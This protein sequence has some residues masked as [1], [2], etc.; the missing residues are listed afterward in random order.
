M[1]REHITKRTGSQGEDGGRYGERE[2]GREGGPALQANY[3]CLQH[4]TI[5]L[6]ICFLT[7]LNPIQ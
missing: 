3:M 5:Y 7:C 4:L 1:R 2:R 6:L